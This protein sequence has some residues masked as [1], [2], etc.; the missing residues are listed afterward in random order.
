[1][2]STNERSSPYLELSLIPR[3][4]CLQLASDVVRVLTDAAM[5]P[6]PLVLAL[7]TDSQTSGHLRGSY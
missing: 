5:D 1:M 2:D 6:N 3:V 7:A 4:V